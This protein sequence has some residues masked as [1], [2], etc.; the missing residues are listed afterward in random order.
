MHALKRAAGVS[1]LIFTQVVHITHKQDVVLLIWVNGFAVTALRARLFS[2]HHK[3][4]IA[5]YDA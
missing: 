4:H 2:F 3:V 5:T 1:G